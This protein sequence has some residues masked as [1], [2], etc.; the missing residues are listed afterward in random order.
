[1]KQRAKE[2]TK[3]IFLDNNNN[4]PLASAVL[5]EQKGTNRVFELASPP[6]CD[7]S[8]LSSVDVFSLNSPDFIAW[9][10]HVTR[11]KDDEVFFCVDEHI[12]S[13]LRRHL[14]I[15]MP[16]RAYLFPASGEL[17]RI[18]VI[19]KDISCGGIAFFSQVS[20]PVGAKYEIVLPFTERPIIVHIRVLRALAPE[21]GL[22]ACEFI[23][24][25]PQEEAMIQER[26]FE[27][28]L[29]HHIA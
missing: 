5:L 26:I 13:N 3:F 20:L 23:D 24:L 27:Y 28:D 11:Q 7:L 10:G 15:P 18:P 1:M 29:R 2:Y 21:R 6:P 22:Y 17:K 9:R 4:T 12:D 16:F 25:L 14:R 8:T 19:S